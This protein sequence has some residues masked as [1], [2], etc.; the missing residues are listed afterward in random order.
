MSPLGL[1]SCAAVAGSIVQ[2]PMIA[3]GIKA[4]KPAIGPA[5]PMSKTALREGI[6]E[7]ILMNAPKVPAGPIIGGVGRKKGSVASTL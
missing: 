3:T 6:G 2:T 1:A 5:T 7:R 4:I